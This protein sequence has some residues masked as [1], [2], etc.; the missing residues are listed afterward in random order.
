MSMIERDAKGRYL[1]GYGGRPTGS[2]D[3]VNRIVKECVI[4][5]A[6][7]HGSDGKGKGQLTGFLSMLIRKDL[8]T[9]V[10]VAAHVMPFDLNTTTQQPVTY[11]SVEDVQAE[12][13]QR[14]IGA[15]MLEILAERMR[16]RE[17]AKN[18]GNGSGLN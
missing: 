4:L 5:A 7:Q 11:R 10:G 2:R 3:R 18:G 6:E 1:P 15:G 9:F 13:A 14:G 12:L 8:K 16:E 17:R